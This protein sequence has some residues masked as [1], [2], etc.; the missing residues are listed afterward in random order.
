MPTGTPI[1]TVDLVREIKQEILSELRKEI[2]EALEPLV[3]QVESLGSDLARLRETDR[4]T[5]ANRP[6][7]TRSGP[8]TE[9]QGTGHS[10]YPW[11][12][13]RA[14]PRVG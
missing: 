7:R 9:T 8:E 14:T 1:P 6:H 11:E 2:R 10:S 5:R 4:A 13:K 12:R 3:R